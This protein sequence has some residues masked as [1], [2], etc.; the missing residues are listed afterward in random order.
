MNKC[1]TLTKAALVNL[2]DGVLY[3]DPDDPGAYGPIGP[4]VRC[5]FRDLSW[6]LLDPQP[7]APR[8]GPG[9]P[10]PWRST[11]LARTVRWPVLRGRRGA[12]GLALGQGVGPALNDWATQDDLQFVLTRIN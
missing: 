10:K 2:L 5:S 11:F 6:V 8:S 4:I 7:L 1:I 12:P 3:P 9:G